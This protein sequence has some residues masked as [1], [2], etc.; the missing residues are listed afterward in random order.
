MKRILS[1]FLILLLAASLKGQSKGPVIFGDALSKNRKLQRGGTVLTIAGGVALFAGNVMYWN[2][3]NET[4][5]DEPSVEKVN[6]SKYLMFGGLGLM[7]VGIPL[8]V[9]GKTKERSIKI[10]ANLV[11]FNRSASIQGIGLKIRF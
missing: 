2:L 4:G 1:I 9:I 5:T 11:N 3:Y 6:T 10:E 7:A 8:L